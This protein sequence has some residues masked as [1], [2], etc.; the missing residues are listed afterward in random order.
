LR[1]L[2]L[3]PVAV[4]VFSAF[5]M[6]GGASATASS[7][8]ERYVDAWRHGRPE[9]ADRLLL[10]PMGPAA[11]AARWAEADAVI[12]SRLA[13]FASALGPDA[14]FDPRRPFANLEF[15][16]QP[17][18][19]PDAARVTIVVVHH[20]SVRSTFLGIVPTAVQETEVLDQI[21]TIDLAAV[22]LLPAGGL[23]DWPASRAW[24]VVQLSLEAP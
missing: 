1:A 10:V 11:M 6:V 13:A 8:M 3:L 2:A 14:G 7:T 9:V 15:R 17:T 24:R 21:G 20:V 4:I 5:W 22:P 23:G 12:G 18:T 19:T 16:L